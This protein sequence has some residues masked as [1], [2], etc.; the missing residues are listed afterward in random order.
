M[1][2]LV[3]KLGFE[4]S[5]DHTG[6]QCIFKYPKHDIKYYAM[7]SKVCVGSALAAF[8]NF[9][10]ILDNDKFSGAIT[11]I[12]ELHY[13]INRLELLMDRNFTDSLNIIWDLPNTFIP[14]YFLWIYSCER[15]LDEFLYI[16]N[17]TKNA[18]KVLKA[19]DVQKIGKDRDMFGLVWGKAVEK[20]LKYCSTAIS[21][22]ELE[23][24]TENI[25]HACSLLYDYELHRKVLGKKQDKFIKLFSGE[26]NYFK[27]TE[28]SQRLL[29]ASYHLNNIFQASER[30]VV[31]STSIVKN[32]LQIGLFNS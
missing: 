18:I 25:H 24:T 6:I 22:L 28:Q 23:P 1:E 30:I 27:K 32:T 16:S 4:Y 17:E 11:N 21:T 20:G 5:S 12:D 14:G 29:T 19:E 7:E 13:S 3:S 15:I 9:Q 26:G 10:Q 31:F 2:K 8:N